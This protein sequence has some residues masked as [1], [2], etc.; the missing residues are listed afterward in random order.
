MT[1]AL[2]SFPFQDFMYFDQSMFRADILNDGNYNFDGND[3]FLDIVKWINHDNYVIIYVDEFHVP[4]TRFYKKKHILHSELVFGYDSDSRKLSILNFSKLSD[5]IREIEVE[6]SDVEK[7]IFSCS[8]I[9]LF[10]DEKTTWSHKGTEHKIVLI[11]FTFDKSPVYIQDINKE[12]IMFEISNYCNSI[13]SSNY[14]NYFTGKLLGT[15]GMDCY[16]AVINI[17]NNYPP[18]LR[19]KK[20][21]GE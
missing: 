20:W 4:G 3:I 12:H 19:V 8:T 13:N 9:E 11:R 2:E 1:V 15:W 5:D 7:A 17:L 21:F 6:Y 10:H 16:K 18:K 14:T